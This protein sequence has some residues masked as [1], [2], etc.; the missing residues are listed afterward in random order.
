MKMDNTQRKIAGA[1]LIATQSAAE[2]ASSTLEQIAKVYR[3]AR[4]ALDQEDS[5]KLREK[6]IET[7][8]LGARF[9]RQIRGLLYARN[10]WL[11]IAVDLLGD[12]EIFLIQQSVNKSMGDEQARL[13][14]S[15]S[16]P[17]TSKAS[18]N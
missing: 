18:I 3:D 6:L 9:D 14:S 11:D 16:V 10:A 12:K 5:E 1:Y 13:E 17:S 15:F 4:Y 8:V 2:R 7:D